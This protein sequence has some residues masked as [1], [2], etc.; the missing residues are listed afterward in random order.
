MIWGGLCGPEQGLECNH[1]V[2]HKRDNIL[3]FKNNKEMMPQR[4]VREGPASATIRSYEIDAGITI[5]SGGEGDAM[6]RPEEQ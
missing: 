2:C 3:K 4:K 1:W 5:R 6:M